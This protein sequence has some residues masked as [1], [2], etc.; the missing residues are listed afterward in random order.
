[1]ASRRIPGV[2]KIGIACVSKTRKIEWPHWWGWIIRNLSRTWFVIF[3][4]TPRRYQSCDDAHEE[5]FMVRSC[6]VHVNGVLYWVKGA[7]LNPINKELIM[8]KGYINKDGLCVRLTGSR[9]AGSFVYHY[10]GK[11]H[12]R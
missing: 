5:N 2:E 10:R 7:L 8:K 9:G 4:E 3:W 6:V 11:R 12:F 1:M